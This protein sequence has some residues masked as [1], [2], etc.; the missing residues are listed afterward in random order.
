M[1][2]H[3]TAPLFISSTSNEV[4]DFRSTSTQRVI[5]LDGKQVPAKFNPT[6][7]LI[8]LPLIHSSPRGNHNGPTWPTWRQDLYRSAQRALREVTTAISQLPV[9]RLLAVLVLLAG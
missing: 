4:L 2:F 9:R 1:I 7:K 3:C 5:L 6:I 8:L